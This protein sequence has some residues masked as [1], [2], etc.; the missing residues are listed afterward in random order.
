VQ[1]F[2]CAKKE[3]LEGK[4]TQCSFDAQWLGKRRKLKKQART[5]KE[6]S[7]AY[8]LYM[9][10]CVYVEG[11]EGS[12]EEK[13]GFTIPLTNNSNVCEILLKTQVK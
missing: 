3:K 4:A 8:K 5:E 1:K 6:N 2:F 12:P 9:L 13:K 10:P 7:I 11:D